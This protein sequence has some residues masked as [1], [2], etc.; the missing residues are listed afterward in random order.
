[1]A[2]IRYIRPDEPSLKGWEHARSDYDLLIT[3]SGDLFLRTDDNIGSPPHDAGAS[4]GNGLDI[5]LKPDQY[6]FFDGRTT[7]FGEIDTNWFGVNTMGLTGNERGITV[8]TR[9]VIF[10]NIGGQAKI[11]QLGI[12]GIQ[13]ALI[14]GKF[15]PVLG[16]GHVNYRGHDSES[17]FQNSRGRYGIEIDNPDLGAI[18][19]GLLRDQYGTDRKTC[20]D[21]E[22]SYLEMHGGITGLQM[23]ADFLSDT[24]FDHDRGTGTSQSG[25]MWNMYVHNNYFHDIDGEPIYAGHTDGTQPDRQHSIQLRFENNRCLR[26]GR[27]GTQI[28]RLLPGSTIKHNVIMNGG[29]NWLRKNPHGGKN[30]QD[31]GFQVGCRNGGVEVAYNIIGGGASDSIFWQMDSSGD[32]KTGSYSWIGT[33]S[34]INTHVWIHHNYI[35]GSRRNAMF[36][37]QTSGMT[38]VT[39]SFATIENNYFDEIFFDYDAL[40]LGTSTASGMITGNNT[41]TFIT[42]RDNIKKQSDRSL[43]YSFSPV[44]Q[45]VTEINTTTDNAMDLVEFINSGWDDASREYLRFEHWVSAVGAQG[46]GTQTG[47]FRGILVDDIV[48]TQDGFFYQAKLAHTTSNSSWPGSGPSWST[49]WTQIP[50]YRDDDVRLVLGST[51]HNL[52]IGLS[53]AYDRPPTNNPTYSGGLFSSLVI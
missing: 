16:T 14:T 31:K 35:I 12:N 50:E 22:V 34:D 26:M 33:Q 13:H 47:V 52:G 24:G 49:Y 36:C 29:S 25:T 38:G 42:F 45:R 51:Y 41:S 8:S 30:F 7:E 20:T 37:Q 9:P 46:G 11:G 43:T 5:V 40:E 4:G 27:E 28:G 19:M 17:G 23:K 21:V 48:T 10:T 6:I 3:G 53:S 44:T 15:D 39:N 2:S 32:I 1:M 18:C